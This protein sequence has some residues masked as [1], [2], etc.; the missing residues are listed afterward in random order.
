MKNLFKGIFVFLFLITCGVQT[1]AAASINITL[2]GKSLPLDTA[3]YVENGRT[4]VPV[5]GVLE[6]LGYFV[7]W[8]EETK[9][10][11]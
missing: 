11:L 1:A 2:N 5:R 6:S 9:T 8:K 10:V 4:L 3:P 7:E